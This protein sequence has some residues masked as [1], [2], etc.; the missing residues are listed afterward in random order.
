MPRSELL[1]L[2]EAAKELG[3]DSADGLGLVLRGELH[4]TRGDN[5]RILVRRED[6][7][8][9]RRRNQSEASQN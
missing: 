7:D 4:P 9:Y 5:G 3:I 6:L 8:E 2:R 1:E